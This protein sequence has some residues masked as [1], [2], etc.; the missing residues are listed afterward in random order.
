MDASKQQPGI[1]V[2]LVDDHS[3][4][5]DGL[6]MLLESAGDV[7]I[8]GEAANG[9]EAVRKV[10]EHGPDVVVLDVAMPLLSGAETARQIRLCRP[11]IKILVLTTYGER[12]VLCDLIAAGVTG[13]LTKDVA[14]QQL[15]SAV[16]TVA[17][18]QPFFSPAISKMLLEE[19]RK[20]ICG[21]GETA[22]Q[23][24][25]TSRET[26][27]LQLAAEGHPNKCIA[28]ILKISMKTVEKHRQSVMAKLGIHE[29]AS[30][31]RYAVARRIVQCD[32]YPKGGA[33]E[34]NG[35]HAD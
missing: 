21:T 27:V 15:V 33:Q 3:V 7:E 11:D 2:L 8:I 5:R 6:R 30:L 31:T 17:R 20:A 4:V 23:V 14:S 9:H 19:R 24:R 26:E 1:R 29:V 32:V 22:P 25:L 10:E 13:Y 28:D 18:G 16:R 12:E 34:G 35:Q